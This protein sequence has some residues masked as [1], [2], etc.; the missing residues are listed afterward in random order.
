MDVMSLV[1]TSIAVVML[2]W[3]SYN[4]PPV[5]VGFRRWNA[6]IKQRSKDDE[7]NDPPDPPAEKSQPR[8]S[9]IVPVKNEA[10]VVDRLL[11]RLVDLSYG[12]KEIILVE[13]GSTD[14]SL[15]I[16]T[17]WAEKHPDL[18]KCYHNEESNGKPMA[19]SSAAGKA[20]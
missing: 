17:Q 3:V 2:L 13:D 12:N 16:C 7:A 9:I 11:K 5:I 14:N 10:E 15:Q 1:T 8:I 18:V 4:M 19:I 20:T 6:I